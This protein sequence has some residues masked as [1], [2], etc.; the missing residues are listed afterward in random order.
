VSQ[1]RVSVLLPVGPNA[2]WFG[3]TLESLKLQTYDSWEL[4]VVLDGNAESN[5]KVLEAAKL[6]CPVTVIEHTT[7]QGIARSLNAGL[8]RANGDLIARTDADDVN[9]PQRLAE[10]VV[11]FD[12]DS[13][14]ILLGSSAEV[15]DDRGNPFG[16][17]RIVPTGNDVL[18]RRLISRNSFIHP[19]VMFRKNI[20]ILSGGYNVHCMRT[21]DYELWLRLALCG[22][23][24]NLPKQLIRYRVHPGQHTSGKVGISDS[25]SAALLDMK[26]RLA[27]ELKYSPTLTRLLHRI[28]VWNR[29]SH[30][31]PRRKTV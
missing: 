12:S 24:D 14:L 4:V 20:A 22:K 5:R 26:L 30:A 3:E 18:K 10:Q 7:S 1:V 15:I 6:N 29:S 19:S 9:F 28:W 13:D 21:E 16:S 2:P 8:H 11:A 23:V 25:E 27:K 17:P 31:F